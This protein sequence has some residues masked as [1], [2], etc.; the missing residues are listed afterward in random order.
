M[1]QFLSVLLFAFTVAI[2]NA[3]VPAYNNEK[4]IAIKGY[5]PVAY[6]SDH[7][8]VKGST[9]FSHTWQGAT[10][11]FKNQANL[12]SFKSHPSTYAPEFGGYCAYGVSENHKAPIDPAAFTIVDNKL[13]LNYSPEVKKLWIKDT[14]GRIKKAEEN[15]KTLKDSKE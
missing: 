8:A 3:Q 15:W 4:G 5:D 14:K 13:Y 12:D 2:C 11:H 10:W 9:E 7:A 6:F 1:K